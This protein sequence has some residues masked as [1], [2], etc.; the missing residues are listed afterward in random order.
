M[1]FVPGLALAA[2]AGRVDGAWSEPVVLP[3]PV[4]TR[5]SEEFSAS[6]SP[7]GSALF[8]MST[9]GLGRSAKG[10]APWTLERLRAHGR[11]PGSGRS[12]VW[13]RDAAF[14]ERLRKGARFPD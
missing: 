1:P 2:A 12:G 8:F 5:G 7:D 10:A 13:W 11:S 6:L 3:S 9:R 14:L 4:S